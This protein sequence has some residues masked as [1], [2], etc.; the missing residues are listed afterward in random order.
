MHPT[1]SRL[2]IS[3]WFHRLQPD[4]PGFSQEEEDRELQAEKEFSSVG[5]LISKKFM[6]AFVEYDEATYGGPSLPGSRMSTEHLKFLAHFINPAYLTTK[7]QSTLFEKFG[8][9]SHLLL[10]DFLRQDVA[11]TLERVLRAKDEEDGLVWWHGKQE[12]VGFDSVR[13]QHHG[14]GTNL[15]LI[16]I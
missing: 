12:R 5:S 7:I 11:D 16:H 8:E 1:Q 14:V 6:D 4:E 3:G 2:S 9:D 15:S 13:I 10:S